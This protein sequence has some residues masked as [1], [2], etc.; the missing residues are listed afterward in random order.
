M[1]FERVSCFFLCQE[2]QNAMDGNAV[3]R[4]GSLRVSRVSTR[5][6]RLRPRSSR[7]VKGGAICGGNGHSG[8]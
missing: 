5:N 2:T 4:A 1:R 6:R 8:L 7:G 3:Y